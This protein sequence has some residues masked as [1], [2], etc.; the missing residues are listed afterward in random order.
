MTDKLKAMLDKQIVIFDGATGTELYKRDFFINSSYEGLVLSNPDVIAEIHQSYIDAGAYVITTNTYG[1]NRNKLQ[2]FGLGDKVAEI[3]RKG[4]ELARG[5][6]GEGHLVGGSVGPVG[7][8]SY[9]KALTDSEIRDILAEQ[10]G[11]LADA[12]VDFILFESLSNEKGLEY[13]L[14]VMAGFPDLPY[15][16]SFS[17]EYDPEVCRDYIAR[18][19]TVIQG[20]SH[21]PTAVGLNCGSGADGTL[22]LLEVLMPL[23]PYPVIVQPNAGVPKSV[24]NRMMYMCSPEYLTTYVVRYVN[25]GARGV[26]GCCG[27]GPEHIRDVVRSVRPLSKTL[28]APQFRV[29]EAEIPLLDPIPV[30][31]RSKLSAK[32]SRGEWV[33]SVEVTPPRGFDLESTIQKAIQCREAG[34][35]A[36]NI[37]DG[38]RASSRISPIVT[39][40]EIQE[41]AGLEAILHCCCRDKNLIG[42]QADLL[43]CACKGINNILFITG[44]PPKL[45]DYPFAS[46]VFDV[47]SIGILKVQS[48]LNRGV[49][50]GGKTIGK[51]TS[52]F[53]GAGADPNA[54]D[55]ERELRRLREKVE[56]GA[57][58]IITQPVF[59]VAPLLKMIEAIADLN[60]PVIAGIWPLASY[61][62]A[63]FMK[64][65]VP[66]VVV[67]DAVMSRMAGAESKEAQRLEGIAI[68]RESIAAIRHAVQGVQVSAPFGNVGT[69]LEVLKS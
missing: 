56:S 12:G 31:E 6:C 8:S 11:A 45:G 21:R 27:I 66:G 44:D 61:R 19:I 55:M 14:D 3:N 65:E 69:A 38:P 15:V 49:D 2:R 20:A 64:N 33:T 60:V 10:V 40:I 68:A 50:I 25:L 37:P 58:F 46:A 53:G 52:F 42:M 47:D 18:L 51:Q 34:V 22:S 9:G 62:N 41:K 13:A 23:C 59:D 35:D 26:G 57:E 43:G 16:P 32:L 29:I 30:E 7:E 4:V 5:V 54:L 39:A 63:E 28:V 48:Q 24:D 67:P 36:M 1:A 17:G